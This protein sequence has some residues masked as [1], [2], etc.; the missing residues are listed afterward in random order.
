[1]IVGNIA[2]GQQED[3]G[4]AF[5]VDEGMPRERKRYRSW[6]HPAQMAEA[7]QQAS[8]VALQC[9][10]ILDNFRPA[11]PADQVAQQQLQPRVE[12]F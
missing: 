9:F 1:V 12:N 4:A 8:L 10:S 3:E 11:R 7:P 2:G 5:R 6:Q